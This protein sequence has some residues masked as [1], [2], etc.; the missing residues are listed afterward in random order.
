MTLLEEALE[1]FT[2]ID[3]ITIPDGYGGK[4]NT[5]KDGATIR[6]AMKFDSSIAAQVAMKQGVKSVYT[7]ITSKSVSIEFHDVLRRESDKK[8]FRVT[9]DGN[10]LK[11]P[12][13]SSLDMQNVTCE[14][15]Q[16][17]G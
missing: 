9:M 3:R 4:K 6:G 7:F 15:W 13:S 11:T 17:D 16:L 1:E 10:D 14:E 12:A 5:W 2:F 8:I